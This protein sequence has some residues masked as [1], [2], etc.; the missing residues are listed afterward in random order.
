[1]GQRRLPGGEPGVP[2]RKGRL[3]SVS[4]HRARPPAGAQGLKRFP[5]GDTRLNGLWVHDPAEVMPTGDR[6]PCAGETPRHTGCAGAAQADTPDRDRNGSPNPG[7]ERAE[8]DI[9]GGLP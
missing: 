8:V 4:A 1:M 3:W 2:R 6:H 7:K 9:L 5:V